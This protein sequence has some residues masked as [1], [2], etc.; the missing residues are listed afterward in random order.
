MAD[1]DDGRALEDEDRIIEQM[2]EVRGELG[3][4]IG[5]LGEEWQHLFDW[6]AYVRS[7]PLTSVVLAAAVGYLIVPRRTSS[8]SHVPG[9]TGGG[10][11]GSLMSA[12]TAA[13][14]QAASVYMADLL[15]HQL[16]GKPNTGAGPTPPAEFTSGE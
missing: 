8:Q 10:L 14:A 13:V 9:K 5:R 7:A 3:G 16:N 2:D 15:T 11:F 12:V 4:G 6:R 1:Q